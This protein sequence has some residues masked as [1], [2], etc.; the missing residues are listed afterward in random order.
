[1]WGVLYIEMIN[2]LILGYHC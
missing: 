2:S 1:M